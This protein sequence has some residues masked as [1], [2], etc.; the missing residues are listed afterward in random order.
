MPQNKKPWFNLI[1]K[2]DN[3]VILNITGIIGSYDISVDE[4][5]SELK[6][7]DG[8][9]L[10]LNIYSEGGSV[11][12][13]LAC[14]NVI[15][16][17]N[18][19]VTGIVNPLAASIAVYVL[20]ACD[21]VK[22]TPNARLMI[23]KPTMGV[24]GD[25][26]EIRATLK[27][28]EDA[29]ETILQAYSEKTGQTTKQ[30]A[31]QMESGDVW[32]T[33][34]EAVDVGLVDEL[35]ESTELS[36][37][38][39]LL[40][41][42]GSDENKE[43]NRQKAVREVFN[44][45]DANYQ[46]QFPSLFNQC[47]D[48]INCTEEQARQ[49]LLNKLGEASAIGANPEKINSNITSTMSNTYQGKNM[50]RDLMVNALTAR[51][52]T[53]ELINGNQYKNK[54]LMELAAICVG[55][56][57]HLFGK[58]ELVNRAFNSS[59]FGRVIGDSIQA[60]IN[61]EMAQREPLFKRL[62]TIENLPDF[63]ERDLI[64]IN[65]APDLLHVSEDGEYKDA[66]ISSTGEKIKL[67]TFGREIK[68]TRE[69]IINDDIDLIGKIPR[70][71]VQAAFRL[72][73]KLMFSAIF[74]GKMA[75]GESVFI[76]SNSQDGVTKDDYQALVMACYTKIAKQKTSHG[77][78]LGLKGDLLLASIDHGATLEAV[79]NTA[80]KPDVFNPA[81]KKFNEVISTDYLEAIN[82]AIGVTSRDFESVVMGFLDGNSAPLL[83]TKE[84]W[85]TDGAT[86]RITYDLSSKVVDRRGLSKATFA[87]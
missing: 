20:M 70:K 17:H 73:D 63:K 19:N 5:R 37:L 42:S 80:S 14:Y 23:H 66:L 83:E 26:G 38:N 21:T 31:K 56:K 28:I 45:C 84:D 40:N 65:D 27:L 74:D 16:A 10:E 49:L 52:G 22:A 18:G 51:V 54:S 55:G 3:K 43:Y 7:Y 69:A 1:N 6:Q 13:G 68:V 82:G 24:G 48:D 67:A 72:A 9:D 77:S 34:Q 87:N 78:P 2:N 50:N 71:M 44:L 76:A 47:L 62:A 79:I 25:A 32:F 81:Y 75:D 12:E 46:A 57:A 64:T 30:L 58:R 59:D 85:S 53:G 36:N 8:M 15:K 61:D 41:Q 86:F 29:Q 60:V 39:N 35:I 33:A 4:L 11:L